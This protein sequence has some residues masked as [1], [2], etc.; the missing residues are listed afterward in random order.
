[1]G[2]IAADAG[3]SSA[4]PAYFFEDKAGVYEAVL[5]RVFAQREAVLRPVG[6]RVVAEARAAAPLRETDLRHALG[7]VVGTYV[8]FLQGHPHFVRLMAWEAL[9]ESRRSGPARPPHSTAVQDAL[10]GVLAALPGPRR[11]PAERRQ[12]HITTI[13]LCFFPF[14][15]NDTMLAGIGVDAHDARFGAARVRHIVDLLVAALT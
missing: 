13:G 11:P 1:M 5:D 6:E 7:A 10:D 8:D 2:R 4:L 15:H 12:L 3:V 14:A 9:Q